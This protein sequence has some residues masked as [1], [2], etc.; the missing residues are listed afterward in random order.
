MDTFTP[1]PK[2]KDG[3]VKVVA[4]PEPKFIAGIRRR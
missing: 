4:A 2:M 1:A 3:S